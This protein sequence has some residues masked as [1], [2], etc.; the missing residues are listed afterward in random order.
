MWQAR[1]EKTFPGL[2]KEDVWALWSDVNN[3]HQWDGDTESARMEG[4]F[5]AGTGFVLRPMGG[6]NVKITITEADPSKGFTDVTK[7]PLAK[8]FDAHEM[9]ETPEGLKLISILRVVGPLSFLWRKIVAEGVARGVPKQLD[10]L[11]R[12]ALKQRG[13]THVPTEDK[14]SQS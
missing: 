6:P 7:F 9:Q 2:R 1:Y 5:R 12:A 11:A 14:F 8:M 10:A 13:E 3:W 4:E